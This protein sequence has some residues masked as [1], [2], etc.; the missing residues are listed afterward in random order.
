[1]S[2]QTCDL[3]LIEGLC[4]LRGYFEDCSEYERGLWGDVQVIAF[5]LAYIAYYS[6]FGITMYYRNIVNAQASFGLFLTYGVVTLSYYV[7]PH[8]P[9]SNTP[10]DPHLYDIPSR[11]SAYMAYIATFFTL[12]DAWSR[13]EE[14]LGVL[15]RVCLLSGA[16]AANAGAQVSL[17]VRN[18]REV[19]LGIMS[20]ALTAG[21]NAYLITGVLAKFKNT[22]CAQRIFC[23]LC[24]EDTRLIPD[25][26]SDPYADLEVR[27]YD[28]DAR[29]R[30]WQNRAGRARNWSEFSGVF[31][32]AADNAHDYRAASVEQSKSRAR[33]DRLNR[34]LS[35]PSTPQEES[36]STHG[37]G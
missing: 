26:G 17:G 30:W 20:G 36:T 1:M 16:V 19:V 15:W 28:A 21:L 4:Y 22:R 9:Q 32:P 24:V 18:T 11:P 5:Y 23:C 33:A 35:A 6:V 34:E 37:P 13:Q 12:Y 3:E 10:C 7:F 31:A 25:K 29:E 27:N 14:T 2:T 8:V